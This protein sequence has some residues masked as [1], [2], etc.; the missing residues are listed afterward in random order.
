LG[1]IGV[2]WKRSISLTMEDKM[3]KTK[4]IDAAF[5]T[6]RARIRSNMAIIRY[7]IKVAEASQSHEEMRKYDHEYQEA[8]VEL[9]NIAEEGVPG[10]GYIIIGGDNKEAKEKL[11]ELA[12]MLNEPLGDIIIVD[13]PHNVKESD[14]DMIDVT[15]WDSTIK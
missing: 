8:Q 7:R 6:R 11:N 3:N 15:P 4:L 10:D 1:K 13:D 14:I 12:A 5:K 2:R 9:R